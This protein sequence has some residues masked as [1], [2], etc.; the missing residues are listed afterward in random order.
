MLRNVLRKKVKVDIAN[1]IMCFK[2]WCKIF[3]GSPIKKT[4]PLYSFFITESGEKYLSSE[5]TVKKD[6]K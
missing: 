1:G 2:D 4:V 6:N 3:S 5:Q